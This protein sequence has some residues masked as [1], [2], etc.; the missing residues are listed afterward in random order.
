MQPLQNNFVASVCI[1][2]NGYVQFYKEDA[3]LQ[4]NCPHCG[5][6]IVLCVPKDDAFTHPILP[7]P[8]SGPQPFQEL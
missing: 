8:Q 1:M 6:E 7:P 2:C 5:R 4:V 3:G